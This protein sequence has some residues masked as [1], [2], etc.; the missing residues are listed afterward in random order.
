MSSSRDQFP[1]KRQVYQL[2]LTYP[3]TKKEAGK[4]VPHLPLLNGRLYESPFEAQLM[5]IFDDK[6]QYLGCSDAYGDE[7][8]LKKGSYVVRAQVRHEDVSKLEKLKQMVLLLNHEI[9]EIPAS[10]FG[11][12]DDV[13]LGG[14]PLDKRSLPTG[15]YVPLFVEGARS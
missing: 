3:F 9:K 8:M 5:M 7:T 11:H 13:A 4:V 14:K 10:V 15:K 12:Q 6:K 1:D 2:I